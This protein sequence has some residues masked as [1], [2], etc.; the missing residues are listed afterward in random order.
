MFRSFIATE[1]KKN[2]PPLLTY[3]CRNC[4]LQFL[5]R[6][7]ICPMCQNQG[8]LIRQEKVKKTQSKE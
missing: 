2:I 4:G 5:S 3:K 1:P 7:G 6:T 8:T